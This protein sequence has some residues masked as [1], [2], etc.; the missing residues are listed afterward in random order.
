MILR[1]QEDGAIEAGASDSGAKKIIFEISFFR[2]YLRNKFF[3]YR[4]GVSH[5]VVR[6]P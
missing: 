3:K 1:W 6:L 2:V 4:N 5:L